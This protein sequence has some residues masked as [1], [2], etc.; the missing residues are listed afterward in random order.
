MDKVHATMLLEILGKPKERVTEALETMTTKLGAEK[1]VSVTNKN[2]HDPAPLEGSN[3]LFTAFSELEVK[4]DEIGD[5]FQVLF[6][7]MPAHVEIT[8]PEKVSFMNSDLNEIGNSLLQRLHN[9]DAISKRV[10]IERDTLIK[11]LKEEF[12]EVFKKLFRDAKPGEG[13]KDSG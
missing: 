4:F 12:P 8:K 2:I 7:Y 13:I 1:G 5:F 6:S 10:L 9:Y 11:R 3:T